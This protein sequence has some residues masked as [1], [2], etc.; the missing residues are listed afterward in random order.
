M[1]RGQAEACVRMCVCDCDE[2][3]MPADRLSAH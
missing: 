3:F 1:A 2:V